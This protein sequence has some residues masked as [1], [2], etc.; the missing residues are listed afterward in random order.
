MV[1]R[2]EGYKGNPNLLRAG[3][4]YSFTQ[5]EMEEY[6]KCR[7][8]IVYFTE[9][10][11]KIITKDNGIQ[12]FLLWDFQ[13][14]IL[15]NFCDYRFNICKL[16]RQVGKST[17]SVAYMLHYILF[18]QYVSVAILAN[19]A[20][21]AREILG[22]LKL[23]YEKLP[24][25]LQAGIEE[26][27][28]GGILLGNGSSIMAE[29]TA[30]DSV[31]GF[32][33][34]LVFLDEFAF[35]PDNIAEDFFTSTYPTISAGLTTKMI[36]V[37]TPK[38]IN[39]FYDMWMEAVEGKSDFHHYEAHWS[40]VPGRDKKW[41]ETTIRN[42]GAHKFQQEYECEFLGSSDTLISGSKLK[43]LRGARPIR[44]EGHLKIYEQ[45]NKDDKYVVT[46]DV[47]EGIGQDYHCVTVHKISSIPFEQVAVYRNNELSTLILP[48]IVKNI[49]HNYN[50]AY[51]MV[52]LNNMGQQVSDIL[53]WDLEYEN[54]FTT[55]SKQGK[56]QF[57]N[58][59]FEKTQNYGVKM[60]T[61]TKR[62]GCDNL[63]TLIESDKY[64]VRD[65]RT[66]DELKSF[67]AKKQSYQAD[68]GKNDDTVMTLVQFAW[69]S[70]QQFFRDLMQID[71][72][73]TMAKEKIQ[74]PEERNIPFMVTPTQL[75]DPWGRESEVIGED[76]W[77]TVKV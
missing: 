45:P 57:I 31:R 30:S 1:V 61:S 32:S 10:Y 27:N 3:T 56:G 22:R 73:D 36:I 9:K 75:L 59:R 4:I 20:T 17:C 11:M 37:S 76:R 34:N 18:N 49:A 33:F 62:I 64:I 67:V 8:D 60:T 15:K 66:I 58:Y 65:Q 53:K 14:D 43:A 55:M 44:E 48:S 16:P 21:T 54:I 24:K 74:G 25:F 52:E 5:E 2:D 26:W 38:G 19:K 70:N 12:P 28:K 23:A 29:S 63:K 13:K 47:S 69:I 46:V 40:M 51:V 41:Y 35:V 77:Y 6:K 42:I 7:N 68:T 72:R 39:H 71:I 50:D